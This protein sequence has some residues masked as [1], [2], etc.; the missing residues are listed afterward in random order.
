MARQIVKLRVLAERQ[1]PAGN[2]PAPAPES[3]ASLMRRIGAGEGDA[4]RA[5]VA[6][7]LDRVVGLSH[8]MLGDA[9]EAED[10]AQD[11]FLRLW[12]NAA[13]WEPRALLGTWLHRVTYNLCVDR[14]RRRRSVSLDEAAEIADPAPG[15]GAVIHL[16]DVSAAVYRQR[17]AI[18]LV[19][20]QEVGNIE[21]ARILG[22]SVEAIESLLARGRRSLK[23]TLAARRPDLL[24]G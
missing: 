23:Q 12:R 21:A 16:K 14:L 5:V 18:L 6:R 24:G 8:H 2:G 7:H 10:V 11:A 13:R 3:D 20:Y 22:V 4:A 17:Q 19:H 1:L 9:A 15:A